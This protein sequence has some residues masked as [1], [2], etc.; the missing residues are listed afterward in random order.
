M[1]VLLIEDDDDLAE[2]VL[3]G[4]RRQHLALDRARGYHE[5]IELTLTTAYD[6]VCLDLGLPDGDGLGLCEVLRSGQ[7]RRPGRI[8]VLTARDGVRDRIAGLDAGADDYLVKPF[9]VL[10]LAARLRALARRQDHRPGGLDV[11]DLRVELA[12]GLAY[13][14]SRELGLTG[15]EFAVLRHLALRRGEVVSAEELLE[16]CWDANADPFTGSVRVILSR[17]RFKLGDPPP[18]VTVRGMG[19]RL[20]EAS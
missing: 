20:G 17:L 10:E 8:I 19:Y 7:V 6:I 16:H 13:R 1:R 11:G 14:G 15:R 18:I 4:L 3:D 9:S 5:A 2:A 12:A